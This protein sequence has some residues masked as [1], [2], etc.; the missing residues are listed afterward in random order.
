M[1]KA[2]IF[3]KKNP[4]NK[5]ES[6]VSTHFSTHDTAM[7]HCGNK[8]AYDQITF[9]IH[10]HCLPSIIFFCFQSSQVTSIHHIL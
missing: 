10:I 5:E 7:I 4:N 9:I 2:F 1:R 3:I 6:D 8:C